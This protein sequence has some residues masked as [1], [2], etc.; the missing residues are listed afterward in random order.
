MNG[1]VVNVSLRVLVSSSLVLGFVPA[2]AIAE[3]IERSSDEQRENDHSTEDASNQTGEE[4]VGQT[5]NEVPDAQTEKT[6]PEALSNN[7]QIN[8]QSKSDLST[9]HLSPTSTCYEWTGEEIN[10]Q[11]NLLDSRY[12]AIDKSQ[13]SLS[14]VDMNGNTVKGAP[15][16]GSY[17]I[18]AAAKEDSDYS[19]SVKSDYWIQIIDIHDLANYSV[20]QTPSYSKVL[21]G[22]EPSFKVSKTYT[23]KDGSSCDSVLQQGIDFEIAEYTYNDYSSGVMYKSQEP[24]TAPGTYSVTLKGIGNYKGTVTTSVSYASATD[25]SSA[26]IESSSTDYELVDGS[27]DYDAQVID[28]EGNAIDPS[29]YNFYFADSYTSKGSIEKPSKPGSYYVYAEAKSGSEYT[30]ETPKTYISLYNLGDLSSD[31]WGEHVQGKTLV[32]SEPI[33][34]LSYGY[35]VL[36]QNKDFVIDHFKDENG[37]SLGKNA[38]TSAGTYKAVIKPK[39]ESNLTGQRSVTFTSY[40]VDSL[41]SCTL[42]Y[43]SQNTSP[44]VV[45]NPDSYVPIKEGKADEPN[46]KVVSA[47]GEVLKKDV[48]YTLEYHKASVTTGQ[49]FDVICSDINTPGFYVVYAVAKDGSRWHGK[50]ENLRLQSYDVHSLSWF[51]HVAKKAIAGD[52]SSFQLIFGPSAGTEVPLE[53]GK[54]Y[55]IVSVKDSNGLKSTGLP[56]GPG[57]YSITVQGIGLYKDSWTLGVDFVSPNGIAQYSLKPGSDTRTYAIGDN[58]TID[59]SASLINAAGDQADLIEGQDYAYQY[60]QINSLSGPTAIITWSDNPPS[61]PGTYIV[62]AKAVDGS[63][64]EGTTDDYALYITVVA[65]NDINGAQ[66]AFGSDVYQVDSDNGSYHADFTGS[67]INLQPTLSLNGRRLAEGVDYDVVSY[68]TDSASNACVVIKGKGAFVGKR[69]IP[70]NI[71][72]SLDGPGITSEPITERDYS[73]KAQ[74]PTLRLKAGN[75]ELVPGTDYTVSYENN[76]DAGT[77][78]VTATGIDSVKGTFTQQFKIKGTSI[79]EAQVNVEDQDYTGEALTPDVTVKL[80]DKTLEKDADYTVEYRDNT[81][82]GEATVTISGRGAYEGT[83]E[84]HFKV[85]KRRSDEPTQSV[86]MY[87]LYNSYTGEHFYTASASER[88]GL[89]V[90]GWNYEGIG[91]TAPESSKSPVYR[92]YNPYVPGGDHHYTMSESERDGLVAVGW[93]YEGIG[94]YS[95]DSEGVALYRQYNPYAATGSHNYTVSKAENDSLVKAGW[96]TEGIAWYGVKQ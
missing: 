18:L 16:C 24:P 70:I 75:N 33:F 90:A 39:E 72:V 81:K 41:S 8:T 82:P 64:L 23:K 45:L 86:T 66:V 54:D 62:R 80:G 76:T 43:S 96:R 6:E 9:G 25:L 29:K 60:A 63:S 31:R 2:P 78:T 59:F 37:S 93:K 27:F 1:K 13:Y 32:G 15:A 11:A 14:L 26:K 17:Y 40:D 92:L 48:D 84:A 83:V 49:P 52:V 88:D 51:T 3:V 30:G 5:S 58:G 53:L 55:E 7:D 79:S 67:D 89:V 44:E 57:R 87:R 38:P 4:L 77:A 68:G 20:Y 22:Q 71:N 95:D 34:E 73:G 35:R 56:S 36:S 47:T 42:S 94:W 74:T 50:T 21:L 91:W 28:A 46:L 69:T 85:T 12:N 61:K 19:G 10:L 65:A